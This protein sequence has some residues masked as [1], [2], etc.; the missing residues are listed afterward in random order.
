MASWLAVRLTGYEIFWWSGPLLTFIIVP[1]LDHLVGADN[2]NPPE[3]VLAKLQS[4][5][6]YRWIIIL[7]LPHQ[8]LS[9]IFACWLFSGGGWST[10]TLVDRI[11]LML[12][13]GVIGGLGINAAHELGHRTGRG[14]RRLSK[15]A[16]AQ[17]F[18]GHFYVEHNRGHHV[19]VATPMD[20]ATARLGESLYR[21][22]PRSIAGGL[23]SAWHLESARL[24][25]R[26]IPVWSLRNEV[27]NAWLLSVALYSVL[28]YWFGLVVLPWLVGQA[29]IGWFLLETVNYIEHYGLRRKLQDTGRYEKVG[30]AHSW[31]SNTIIANVF[32][33]QLQRHSDHHANPQRRYQTLRNLDIAPQLPAGYGTMFLLAHI[34][35]LW[36]HVMD[37]RVHAVHRT[38]S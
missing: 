18:Y 37:P 5:R 2:S 17:T 11:G 6:W 4:V 30:P 12:T 36:R 24:L 16:L 31:N 20:S 9:L 13:L 33:F 34:P 8:Y 3:R 1:A 38:R 35:P 27:L 10:L 28:V 22:L 25:R 32:L 7:Y 21:F 19:R 15:I 29:V 23:R 14:E 26:N